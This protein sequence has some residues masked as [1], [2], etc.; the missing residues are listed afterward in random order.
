MCWKRIACRLH[1]IPLKILASDLVVSA[2]IQRLGEPQEGNGVQVS[3]GDKIDIQRASP[4]LVQT[5]E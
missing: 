3:L 1:P 4:P 2:S 5:P